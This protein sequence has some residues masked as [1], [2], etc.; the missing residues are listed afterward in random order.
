[1]ARIGTAVATLGA[2]LVLGVAAPAATA[3]S[4]NNKTTTTGSTSGP[5][6]HLGSQGQVVFVVLV[7]GGFAA[8][9]FVL[10]FY[11]RFSASRR[12]Y[13]LLPTLVEAAQGDPPRHA[14]SETQITTI[15]SAVRTQPSG[16][17]G[18]TRTTIAMGLVTLVGIALV[19][20]LVG[21]G[22]NASDLLK[23]V[24]TALTAALTTVIGFYF[25]AKTATDAAA[26]NGT[27]T[28][29]GVPGP[30]RNVVAT[31]GDM[32]AS[33]TFDAPTNDGGSTVTGYTVTAYKEGAA[34]GTAT[35]TSSP[36]VIRGLSNGT[37]YTFTVRASNAVG[38][39]PESSAS[40]P[41]TPQT[42]G[43]SPDEGNTPTT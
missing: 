6:I 28:A 40:Q 32:S 37:E 9:W 3:A 7:V 10:I 26:G 29:P 43:G 31:A 30:P 14:L 36:V 2:G 23:T 1:M 12:I 38:D 13:K 4:G 27:A 34:A 16:T 17:R 15:T 5:V 39:G 24:V 41:V 35:G 21:N 25:G 42:S 8:L 22:S 33:V 19:A 11:D 20:L 18:L